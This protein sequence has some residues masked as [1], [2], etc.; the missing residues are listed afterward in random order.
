VHDCF[1]VAAGL[2]IRQQWVN[3]FLATLAEKTPHPAGRQ[4]THGSLYRVRQTGSWITTNTCN[5]AAT[6]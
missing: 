1:G 3:A 5:T 6:L 2:S 4:P